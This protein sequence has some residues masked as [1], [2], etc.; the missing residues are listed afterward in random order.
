MTD[1][2]D[3]FKCS[4]KNLTKKKMRTF[5]SVL[6]IVIGVSSVVIINS[7]A[8]C[9][10]FAVNNELESLGM[11]GITISQSVSATQEGV[12]DS[13]TL[14]IIK[15]QPEVSQA[16]PVTV[17][18]TNIAARDTT[19]NAL[20]FGIDQNAKSMISLNLLY[21]R[22]ISRVDVESKNKVCLVDQVLANTL[23]KRDNMVGK[24]MEL[25]VGGKTERFDVIGVVKTG[26]GLLQNVIGNYA[27]LIYM[28]YSTMQQIS[29]AQNFTQIAVTLTDD[30]KNEQAGEHLIKTITAVTGGSRDGYKAENL[31]KQREGL[32]NMMNIITLVLSLVGFIAMIVAS[33]GIMTIMLVSVGERTREIG[34]K[35]A[36]GASKWNIKMEFLIEAFLMS[37]IGSFL[38]LALGLIISYIG[39]MMFSFTFVLNAGVIAATVGLSMLVGVVFGVY[40]AVKASR[41]KPVEALRNE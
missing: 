5:L 35:K 40:P 22:G 32:S 1:M 11:K 27:T 23:Y 4:V 14:D 12:L 37:A 7:I 16:M 3:I 38:G 18:Y 29:G 24:S 15:K 34:I 9:G 30:Q 36:I 33:L 19:M 8:E 26:S 20:L 2:G 28:P 39:A 10:K 6:A 25:S 41:L 17:L 21:G 13:N 31:M